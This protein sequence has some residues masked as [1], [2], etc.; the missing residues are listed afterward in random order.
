VGSDTSAREAQMGFALTKLFTRT[1]FLATLKL[2]RLG[3]PPFLVWERVKWL[4]SFYNGAFLCVNQT[5]PCNIRDNR[6]RW[7]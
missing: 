1:A 2:H 5:F 3:D 4:G 7:R 6:G